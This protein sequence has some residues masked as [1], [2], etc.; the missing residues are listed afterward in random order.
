MADD[1]QETW[2]NYMS[3]AEI[4]QWARQEITDANWAHVLRVRELTEIERAYTAGEITAKEADARHGRYYERWGDALPTI[5]VGPET[6]DEQIITSL[7]E[8]AERRKAM[9]KTRS[10]GHCR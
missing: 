8:A 1:K 4:S 5:S 7:D 6:T 10:E 9:V 3:P 2:A